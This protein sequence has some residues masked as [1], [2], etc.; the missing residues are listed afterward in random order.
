M[1]TADRVATRHVC[2]FSRHSLMAVGAFG[3]LFFVAGAFAQEFSLVDA[4]EEKLEL[5]KMADG[6]LFD[7]FDHA[8]DVGLL[9]R[10][11]ITPPKEKKVKRAMRCTYYEG[12]WDKLPD[13]DA[14]KPK[15]KAERQSFSTSF[16]DRGEDYALRWKGTL[17]IPKAG[18]YRF[19]V[20]SNDGAK[21][22]ID[23][24][25][26]VDNDGLHL[27]KERSGSIE[28]PKGS[29]PFELQ[30]FNNGGG[31]SLSTY[32]QPPGGSKSALTGIVGPLQASE[33]VAGLRLL[34][35]DRYTGTVSAW[36]GEGLSIQLNWR[37]N[38]TLKVKVDEIAS[39]WLSGNYEKQVER[40]RP[41][42]REPG[43]MAYILKKDVLK[44]VS[45]TARGFRDGKF[46]FDFDGKERTVDLDRL[47]GVEFGE[48]IGTE[49]SDALHQI[50]ELNNGDQ[51]SGNWL[52]YSN[53]LFRF[54]CRDVEFS[55]PKT[56]I[57]VIE[58]RNG[59][60]QYLSDVEPVD[61][62]EVPWFTR[63]MPWTR[64]QSLVGG[65]LQIGEKT[66]AKGLAV[67]ARTVLHYNLNGA[68]EEFRC[69]AG[70]Q[71]KTGDHGNAHLRVLGDG[72]VLFEKKDARG[73]DAAIDLVLAVHEVKQLTLEVD[74]G[75]EED[76][77]DRLVWANA[78][79]LKENNLTE[80][81]KKINERIA[82]E[83]KADEEKKRVAEEKKKAAEKAK[84]EAKKKAEEEAKNPAPKKKTPEA[85]TSPDK[86]DEKSGE[87]AR[88]AEAPKAVTE[89]KP[90]GVNIDE[91]LESLN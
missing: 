66:Y 81:R 59:S 47:V 15:K 89:K 30:F 52:S 22:L 11:T 2:S 10:M 78:R 64:N 35:G 53:D 27:A 7:R 37:T 77:G 68:F 62:E 24:E 29:V 33:D 60:V 45:G 72:N 26:V 13:F 23:G 67:H 90:V 50:F 87:K 70:F 65:P 28:L 9:D 4:P 54:S 79:V 51:L 6:K 19:F 69:M 46:V 80:L 83:K 57:K 8:I 71:R 20:K 5:K 12:K 32:Y 55:E 38:V 39:L 3:V 58:T 21:L 88:P 91:L 49:P 61:V 31:T 85:E 44:A 76:V 25:M 48:R 43:D 42:E 40:I 16:R 84:K 74:F 34:N 14:L 73:S 75:A 86:P 36:E 1:S 41:T 82:E 56:L 18:Q 17:I 63:R